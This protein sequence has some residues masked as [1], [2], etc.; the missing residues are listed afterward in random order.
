MGNKDMAKYVTVQ[1]GPK[2]A[3]IPR[4]M[5]VIVIHLAVCCQNTFGNS[6]FF[7]LKECMATVAVAFD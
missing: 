5:L 3:F 2:G 7:S 4:D 6:K 1:R